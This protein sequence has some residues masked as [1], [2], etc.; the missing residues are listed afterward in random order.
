[1]IATD[2]S[3]QA[4]SG[5]GGYDTIHIDNDVSV[6]S[7]KDNNSISRRTIYKPWLACI[8]VA[9]VDHDKMTPRD[10]FVAASC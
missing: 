6:D 10:L 5:G 7:A 4:G 9:K 8:Y 3:R 2:P 1:M